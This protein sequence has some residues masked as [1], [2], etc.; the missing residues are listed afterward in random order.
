MVNQ[1]KEKICTTPTPLELATSLLYNLWEWISVGMK[2]NG[3]ESYEKWNKRKKDRYIDF[4][5]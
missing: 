1:T 4:R 2:G 5:K 3:I